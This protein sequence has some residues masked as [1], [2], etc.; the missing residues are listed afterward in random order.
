MKCR[1]DLMIDNCK[2]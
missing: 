1:I 2:R